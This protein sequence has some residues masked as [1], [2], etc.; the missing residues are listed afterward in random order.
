M[1]TTRSHG[2]GAR[3][4]RGRC[5]L[6]TATART[7]APQLNFTGTSGYNAV[8]VTF[9]PNNKGGAALC[10]VQVA[11]AGSA[12]RNC[13]TAPMTLT[14]NGLWP[15]NS[16]NFTVS[17]TSAAGSASATGSRGTSTL[18]A[19]VVCGDPSYCGSGIWIYSTTSQSNPNNAVGRFVAGN[20]FLPECNRAGDDVNAQPWGGRAPPSGCATTTATRVVPV[21]L[22]EHG[23]RQQ[24]GPDPRLLSPQPRPPVAPI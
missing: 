8:G 22:G 16:Y 14:V 13:A 21:R 9:T 11:G 4:Q 7:S 2:D 6:T 5:H 23:R 1:A 17:I 12:Q 10:R 18:R 24:P 20:Q 3:R 19:T 15:N